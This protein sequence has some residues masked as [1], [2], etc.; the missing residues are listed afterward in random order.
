MVDWSQQVYVPS[1][2]RIFGLYH[3][4]TRLI[5]LIILLH[6]GGWTHSRNQRS[7]EGASTGMEAMEIQRDRL[8]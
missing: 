3:L 4:G 1:R 6:C 5:N 8:V 7:L 2:S